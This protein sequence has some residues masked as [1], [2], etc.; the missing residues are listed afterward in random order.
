[1]K[2]E[3]IIRLANQSLIIIDNN[4]NETSL[5]ILENKGSNVDLKIYTWNYLGAP[6]RNIKRRKGFKNA[7]LN[8]YITKTFQDNYLILDEKRVYLM[9]LPIKRAGKRGF[10]VCRIY[11]YNLVK[12]ILTQAKGC[13]YPASHRTKM[14][15]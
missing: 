13:E 10:K 7:Q 15:W 6:I 12:H 1:M 9:S 2:I 3:D 14:L 8:C 4:I 5:K 11:D